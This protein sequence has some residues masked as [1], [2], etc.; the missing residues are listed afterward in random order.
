MYNLGSSGRCSAPQKLLPPPLLV[1]AVA[2]TAREPERERE[3]KRESDGASWLYAPGL[4]QIGLR[5]PCV[6]YFSLRFSVPTLPRERRID[7]RYR[8]LFTSSKALSVNAHLIRASWKRDPRAAWLKALSSALFEPL[9]SGLLT[10]HG[11]IGRYDANYTKRKNWNISP[12]SRQI[13]LIFRT[14]AACVS[15]R[16]ARTKHRNNRPSRC[17]ATEKFH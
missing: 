11:F 14:R 10:V 5:G 15:K 16:R 17:D 6:L 1:L 13:I 3:R 9:T 2:R 7:V 4:T 8:D 12:G